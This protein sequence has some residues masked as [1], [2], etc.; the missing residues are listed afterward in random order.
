MGD[1]IY[2]DQN[3]L[4]SVSQERDEYKARLSQMSEGGSLVFVLGLW[5]LVEIAR[6]RNPVMMAQLA[7]VAD[8]LQPGWFPERR[9]LQHY[10]VAEQ[11]FRYV[12]VPYSR[13]NVIRTL[14]EVAA[15]LVHRPA[16]VGQRYSVVDVASAIR[17][18]MAPIQAG[19]DENRRARELLAE[20]WKREWVKTRGDLLLRTYVEKL[21]PTKTP[22]GVQIDKGTKRSF[23]DQIT[24]DLFP[25]IAVEH[26][27]FEDSLRR[28]AKQRIQSFL[29]RQ[30]AIVAL[31]YVQSLVSDDAALIQ[32]AKRVAANLSFPTAR[33]IKKQEFDSM[34]RRV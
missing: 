10:E 6:A 3:F 27:M 1:V 5:T 8:A 4:I 11:F 28:G 2:C 13:P 34:L 17:S 23:L 32:A 30:H 29:D 15:E 24:I 16:P 20:E 33:I 18:N 22:A 31:P 9:W 7:A 26:A 19:F 25:S 21:L 14:A 12:N